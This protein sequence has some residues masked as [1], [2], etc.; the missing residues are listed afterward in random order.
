[1]TV[2]ERIESRAARSAQPALMDAGLALFFVTVCVVTVATAEAS[3]ELREARARDLLT[4]AIVAAPIAVRRRF[5]LA[6]LIVSCSAIVV[7]ITSHAPDGT[8]PLA[9]AVLVYSVAA[10]ARMTQ[11]LAGLAVITIAIVILGAADDTD[12]TTF[13]VIFTVALYAIVWAGGLAMRAR[14]VTSDVRVRE[15]TELAELSEQRAARAVAEERL[16]IAQE[17]H[18]VVAHSI[19]VIAVQAGVGTHFID[20]NLDETRAALAAIGRTSRATLN[21][22]RRLL[23]VLRDDDG[24]GHMPAPTL[25]QLPQLVDD[26]RGLGLPVTLEVTGEP[27]PDHRAIAMSAYRVVQEALT[28]VVKHAGQSTVVSVRLNY[29]PDGIDIGVEDDGRGAGA[30]AS[31]IGLTS[32]RHGLIGMRERVDVWGGELKSGPCTGGGFAVSASFP[33]E[34]PS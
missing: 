21:E 9:V 33:Y 17:L 27:D 2:F 22:L 1:M 16:R 7:L 10:W 29:R 19:S 12:L 5:P 14:R 26:M 3:S 34:A 32:G 23:G 18:D 15:A 30:V 13:D 4:A 11:A 20:D 31:S 25:D 24:I 8:T 6:G 28:N